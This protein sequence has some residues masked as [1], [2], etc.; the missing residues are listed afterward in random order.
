MERC[1][2]HEVRKRP[3]VS[4]FE[5]RGFFLDFRRKPVAGVKAQSHRCLC[6]TPYTSERGGQMKA[7]HTLVGSGLQGLMGTEK[8]SALSHIWLFGIFQTQ[9][10]KMLPAEQVWEVC[11][12]QT[13]SS[14]S[15]SIPLLLSPVKNPLQLFTFNLFL[16]N[17]TVFF[18]RTGTTLRSGLLLCSG[19]KA[20][21]TWPTAMCPRNHVTQS[22]EAAVKWPNCSLW[23]PTPLSQTMHSYCYSLIEIMADFWCLRT[24]DLTGFRGILQNIL[25]VS[26]QG[27]LIW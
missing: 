4:W 2:W 6:L 27:N 11:A 10:R 5:T 26:M 20:V 18:G 19:V 7:K 15:S 8:P 21:T 9:I 13:S 16:E 17:N 1:N 3:H 14:L 25:T 24:P 23:G 12:R 22:D